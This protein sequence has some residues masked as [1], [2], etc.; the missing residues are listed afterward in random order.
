[1]D[2]L[3]HALQALVSCKGAIVAA[4]LAVFL[5]GGALLP[6]AKLPAR[7]ICR[8]AK[9]LSLAGLNALVSPLLVI[10]VTVFAAQWA[11]TWRPEWWQGGWG[12]TL[13][14][15]LLDAWLYA[16]HRVNHVLPAL[17]R[18][19]EV[20]HLDAT[21][22]ASTALRF[23]FGEV[24]ASS[25]WRA[26]VIFLLGM[27]LAS[28]LLFEIIVAMAAI[29][30]HS[31]VRL[32][33]ALERAMA[34][35]IVTP[36]IHWVHHHAKRTDTDSNYATVLSVWDRVFASRS[37]TVR[38][39]EMQMGVEGGQD[40]GLAALLVRPLLARCSVRSN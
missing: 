16:W 9:N 25:L 26:V 14:F 10:P 6:F 23:H 5:I 21:L 19:H 13:D 40:A 24:I 38:T 33:A 36:S 20:H 31:N 7:P 35:V 11:L 3:T 4:F 22:D 39:A 30:H 32:P 28:V 8:I 2:T 1:M 12:L 34:W 27:P 37:A 29:F 18:L 17:W 15:V